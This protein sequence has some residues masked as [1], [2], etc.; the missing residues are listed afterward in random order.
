MKE[1]KF[2]N[3]ILICTKEKNQ[4]WVSVRHVIE[5]IGIIFPSQY[6]YLNESTINDDFE[7]S[8]E[9]KILRTFIELRSYILAKIGTIE[10]KLKYLRDSN[11]LILTEEESKEKKLKQEDINFSDIP[12]K[13]IIWMLE[14][15]YNKITRVKRWKDKISDLNVSSRYKILFCIKLSALNDWLEVIKIKKL[16]VKDI[17]LVT[18]KLDLYKKECKNFITSEFNDS[19]K[20]VNYPLVIMPPST[21]QIS[22]L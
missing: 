3:D 15:Y 5:A 1:I 12:D 7:Y 10:N 11:S 21:K 16:E 9:G 17:E 20:E 13:L 18:K 22:L 19:K 4:I 2:Y 6:I 8:K 14:I